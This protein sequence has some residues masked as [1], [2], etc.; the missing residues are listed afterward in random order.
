MR[1]HDKKRLAAL[2]AYDPAGME[3]DHGLDSLCN[4]VRL[5]LGVPMAA[6]TLVDDNTTHH[7]GMAG[8][9]LGG[10]PNGV[11]FCSRTIEQDTPMLVEDATKD[12]RFADNPFVTANP[13]VR[14]YVGAPLVAPDGSALGA[15]CAVDTAAHACSESEQA[16]L[17][18]LAS[19][20]VEILEMRRRVREVRALALSDGLTGI[21]NRAAI[22]LEIEKAIA[23]VE[24]HGLPFGVLFFDVDHFKS[25]NDL[26][27]HEAGDDLLRLIGETLAATTRREEVC[28]RL[29]GDEFVVLLMGSDPT[30]GRGAAERIKAA[31]DE[32]VAREGFAVSF[33][34]GLA[35][36]PTAPADAEAALK[37]ADR[38]LYAAKRQGKN[39]IV[40][41]ASEG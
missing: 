14:F 35:F 18:S 29:G 3:R 12:A 19:T 38:L 16:K 5:T 11:T 22:E 9:E 33:S 1:L 2:R 4:L 30:N 40:V 15:I 6:V 21:A 31:L 37:A 17:V 23:V 41:E 27:G 34:M 28:G 32:A 24:R 10:L 8:L 20:A 26:R 39:R 36:F 13:G 25:V 7:V